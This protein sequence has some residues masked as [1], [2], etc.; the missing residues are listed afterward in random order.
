M[1]GGVKVL[2]E[3][4]NLTVY[5][6]TVLA[7]D[8]ISLTVGE[9]E[10]VAM[11]GPNGAG[12]STALKAICGLV[13]PKSGEVLFQGENINGKQPYQ[14][15]EK[16]LCLVPEG[17][18]VF[19][20]M[21]VLENLEMGSYTR[22]NKKTLQEYIDK[23]FSIFPLLKERQRQRA[24]T[25]SSGEQQMLAIGRA[26]MLKPKLLLLDEPSLGLSPNYVNTVFEK[27]KEI[28]KDGTTILLVEQNARMALEYADRGYV[29]EIGKI[30]F[31]DKAKN[32]LENDKV[33]KSFL[34]GI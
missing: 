6:D 24:G 25:L 15:V 14:L 16:G 8:D 1:A 4:R 17:R 7:L 21:S 27:I 20:S 5:Y 23:V 29:F 3:V 28:N 18:R 12:K 34:G 19:A 13:K 2:L 33:R 9:G 26:L 22:S 11:I 31:E 32:L 30:A 10:I